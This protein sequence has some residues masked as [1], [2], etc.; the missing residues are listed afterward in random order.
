MDVDR[1]PN[2]L[3]FMVMEYLEGEDLGLLVRTG[4]RFSVEEAIH[5]L[6]QG[7]EAL[8]QAHQLGI[9]HRDIKPANLFLVERG[10]HPGVVKVLDFGISKILDE[11]EGDGQL[12]LTKTTTVLG[13]GLYMS[14]EQMRSAK[15]VDHRTDIYAL[16]IC[17]F[18][19]LA[20]TQPYTAES[21]AELA[22][23]VSTEP[24][25]PLRRHRPELPEELGRVIERAY[26]RAPGDRYQSVAEM[27]HALGP[28][29]AVETLPLI[30]GIVRNFSSV[31]RTSASIP[32]GAAP[33][34]LPPLTR[35]EPNVQV[36]AALSTAAAFAATAPPAPAPMAPLASGDTD[37]VP[38]QRRADSA[39]DEPSAASPAPKGDGATLSTSAAG[40]V[41]APE[42]ARAPRASL[43]PWLVAGALIAAV[44]AAGLW[45]GTRARELPGAS[46][47]GVPTATAELPAGSSGSTLSSASSTASAPSVATPTTS[48]EPAESGSAPPGPGAST[49]RPHG[50]STGSTPSARPSTTGLCFRKDPV[51]GLR[52][53]VPCR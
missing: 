30:E 2:G 45:W 11:A 47:S 1:L 5:Y 18:E 28:F 3:P 38:T 20:G 34:P 22:V 9:V 49:S 32:P 36:L 6:V 4:R 8:A 50:T 37:A 52:V 26:A 51:S 27:V 16:G 13:S 25:A 35:S 40:S 19:L 46:A 42:R 53:A 33:Q 21:F 7:A 43:T 14:P 31:R 39:P 41:A 23:R 17:L 10:E 29:A 15:T 12:A 44:A 48:A 24:P